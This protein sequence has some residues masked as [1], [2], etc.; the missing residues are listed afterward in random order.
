M[1]NSLVQSRN[2]PTVQTA[3]FHFCLYRQFGMKFGRK[4][5]NKASGAY[6]KE[7]INAACV[8]DSTDQAIIVMI[9]FDVSISLK[10]F[11]RIYFS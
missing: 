9:F 6:S 11:M 4:A 5:R 3:A 1:S 10:N 2:H 7:V 8:A